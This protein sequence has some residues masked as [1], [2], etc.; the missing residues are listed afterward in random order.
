MQSYWLNKIY[1]GYTNFDLLPDTASGLAD[2]SLKDLVQILIESK[3]NDEEEF[4]LASP[5][6]ARDRNFREKPIF[7]TLSDPDSENANFTVMSPSSL[8][9]IY[10]FGPREDEMIAAGQLGP[11]TPFYPDATSLG[12]IDAIPPSEMLLFFD[13]ITGFNEETYNIAMEW[14][15][16]PVANDDVYD[17]YPQRG[18]A[19]STI[20]VRRKNAVYTQFLKEMTDKDTIKI[21]TKAMTLGPENVFSDYNMDKLEFKAGPFGIYQDYKIYYL[22]T[23]DNGITPT[24]KKAVLQ[25]WFRQHF[26]INNPGSV[27]GMFAIDS[28]PQYGL[29]HINE[30]FITSPEGDFDNF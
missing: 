18:P 9:I 20:R 25:Y 14:I 10:L 19:F 1:L 16:S 24:Q 3:I 8:L 17:G 21:L 30:N 29:K 7:D 13:E 22:D 6:F 27:Q 5:L 11:Q 12:K 26:L 4:V 15:N 28:K 2:L 23:W